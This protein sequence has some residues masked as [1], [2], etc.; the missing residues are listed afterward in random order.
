MHVRAHQ[1]VYTP[2]RS[3]LSLTAVLLSS[4]VPQLMFGRSLLLHAVFYQISAG[5]QRQQLPHQCL[6]DPQLLS[7]THTSRLR[8]V[9][10]S[11]G[12]KCQRGAYRNN[13]IEMVQL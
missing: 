11:D 5:R 2:V 9:E 3:L 8:N 10:S 13:W 6:K 4:D 12:N 7:C 1:S